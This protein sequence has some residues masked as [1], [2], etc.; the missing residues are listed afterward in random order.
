[1]ISRSGNTISFAGSIHLSDADFAFFEIFNAIEKK[2]Y[3]DIVFDFSN[4]DAIFADA[5][6]PI[7]ALAR[8]YNNDGISFDIMIDNSSALWGNFINAN[9]AHLINKKFKASTYRGFAQHPATIFDDDSSLVLTVN[10]ILD[11]I[12]KTTTEIGRSDLAV[13]EWSLNEIMENSLRHSTSSIGG[14]VHLSKFNK[15]KNHIEIVVAD[16]GV[17]IPF[18]LSQN[19]IYRGLQDFELIKLSIQEGVTRGDGGMGNGLFGAFTTSTNSGGNFYIRSQN[20]FL[21][22]YKIRNNPRILN[23]NNRKIP[24]AGTAIVACYDYSN[25]DVLKESLQFKGKIHTPLD[26]LERFDE[27]ALE[28]II[29][30]EAQHTATRAEAAPLRIKIVNIINKTTVDSIVFDFSDINIMTSSFADEL[31]GKLGVELGKEIYIKSK[32]INISEEN[33]I[34]LQRAVAQRSSDRLM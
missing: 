6:I 15:T 16:S 12:L 1:M 31:F 23:I 10:T 29:K 18:T 2:G 21:A 7:C 32:F 27:D 14:I 4:V 20:G 8:K 5:M 22:S 11:C 13:I 17:G 9:W 26:Y 33:K 3:E 28:I 34:V 19:P 25:K 24:Y 30:N